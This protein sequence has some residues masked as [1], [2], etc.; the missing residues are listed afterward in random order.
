MSAQYNVW[1]RL[2]IDQKPTSAEKC[3]KLANI[4]VQSF[5]TTLDVD[6]HDKSASIYLNLCIAMKHPNMAL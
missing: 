6:Y 5:F 4:F 2:T 3:N 1:H